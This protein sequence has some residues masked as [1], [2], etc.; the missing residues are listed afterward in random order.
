M[1]LI[2]KILHFIAASFSQLLSAL[3]AALLWFFIFSAIQKPQGLSEILTEP[4]GLM[5]ILAT[6][7]M[8]IVFTAYAIGGQK[9]L[10]KVA[11]KLAEKEPEDSID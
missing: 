6:P 3:A 7:L 2:L 9:L 1:E 10:R 11:P 5:V 8:A 4:K